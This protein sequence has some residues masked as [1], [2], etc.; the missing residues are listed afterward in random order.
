MGS[1]NEP[2]GII[3]HEEIFNRVLMRLVYESL[4]TI[5]IKDKVWL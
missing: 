2:S 5:I 3:D 4:I 1:L